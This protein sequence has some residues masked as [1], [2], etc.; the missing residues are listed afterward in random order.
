MRGTPQTRSG[1]SEVYRRFEKL[2]TVLWNVRRMISGVLKRE[3][4][5]T[6]LSSFGLSTVEKV[7]SC[8]CQPP[9]MLDL[10]PHRTD[11]PL[12]LAQRPEAILSCKQDTNSRLSQA[13]LRSV[14][15]I[16]TV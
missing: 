5:R 13:A 10:Q 15:Y 14:Q 9:P 12:V 6:W 1:H 11:M 4:S 2:Q 3:D 8:R 7:I 16:C